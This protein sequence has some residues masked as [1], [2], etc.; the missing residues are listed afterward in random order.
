M[1]GYRSVIK[2]TA[3]ALWALAH[4][5]SSIGLW[6]RNLYNIVIRLIGQV[7]NMALLKQRITETINVSESGKQYSEILDRVYHGE[8]QIIIEKNGIPLAAIVPLSVVRDAEARQR[9]RVRS[10]LREVHAAFAH[11]PEDELES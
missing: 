8:E 9:E 6:C 7:N 10:S 11:V 5:I 1:S 2:A 4:L 3:I